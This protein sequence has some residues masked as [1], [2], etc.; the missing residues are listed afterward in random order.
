MSTYADRA[1]LPSPRRP[2]ALTCVESYGMMRTLSGEI[3]MAT[4][5]FVGR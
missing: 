3:A 1:V 5:S 4:M 2:T